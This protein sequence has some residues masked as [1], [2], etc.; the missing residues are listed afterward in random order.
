MWV[1]CIKKNINT[2]NICL[3]KVFLL[4]NFV[5]NPDQAKTY[6]ALSGSILFDNLLVLL[7]DI[8]K[9]I[10]SK[11]NS[12]EDNNDIITQHITFAFEHRPFNASGLDVHWIL[13]V[14]I[15]GES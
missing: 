14:S 4:V 3:L 1:S 13:L 9:T 7:K 11:E 12:A 5:L 10:L 15:G 2:T 8:F 6:R